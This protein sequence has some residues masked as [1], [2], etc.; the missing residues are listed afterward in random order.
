MIGYQEAGQNGNRFG[1]SWAEVAQSR[2]HEEHVFLLSFV[3]FA[4]D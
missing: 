2:V 3:V 1:Q 4:H